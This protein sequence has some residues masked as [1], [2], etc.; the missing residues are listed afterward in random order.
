MPVRPSTRWSTFNHVQLKPGENAPRSASHGATS[1]IIGD[2]AETAKMRPPSS[3]LEAALISF[4]SVA[5][6]LV[7]SVRLSSH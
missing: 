2:T 7:L 1:L 5:L 6:N 4:V 3:H